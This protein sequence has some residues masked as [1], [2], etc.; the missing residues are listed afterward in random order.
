MALIA[1]FVVGRIEGLTFAMYSSHFLNF[2]SFKL[3]IF[4]YII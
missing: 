2:A 3:I 4:L 1:S